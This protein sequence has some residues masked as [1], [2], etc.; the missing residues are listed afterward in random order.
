[1]VHIFLNLKKNKIDDMG[2]HID[3][4]EKNTAFRPCPAG[5]LEEP[6]T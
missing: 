3:D 1:M 6:M 5:S 2:N 4:L